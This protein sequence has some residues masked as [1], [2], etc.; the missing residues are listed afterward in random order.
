MSETIT[1][2]E[3]RQVA[4][5]GRLLLSDQEVAHFRGQLA[6]VLEHVA[7]LDELD[8]SGVEPMFQPGDRRSVTRS[9]AERDGLPRDEALANAPDQRDGFFVVP[10]VLGDS[11][12]A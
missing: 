4:K 5:L 2:A 6:A 8:V 12:G 1:E 3:V 10:K 11:G 9:D 7:Q